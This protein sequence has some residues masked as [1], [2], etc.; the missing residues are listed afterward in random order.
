MP[1]ILKHV[2]SLLLF[3]LTV[4]LVVA[5]SACA[6]GQVVQPLVSTT[7]ITSETGQVVNT[8][9]PPLVVSPLPEP[10]Q[11]ELETTV[12][13]SDLLVDGMVL[14]P[15]DLSYEAISR[16]PTVTEVAIL[17]CPGVYENQ[18]SRDWFGVPLGFILKDADV[19]PGAT[20]LVFYATDGYKMVLSIDM[21]I[22]SAAILAYK[23]DGSALSPGDGY[24]YR[25]ISKQLEGPVW[26]KGID[27]IMVE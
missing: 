16:Y 17:Y 12:T 19:K 11:T 23:V 9:S 1:R 6:Q 15:L 8:S 21:V 13:S 14:T 3:G 22:S 10:N 20:R 25:L 18:P 2:K 5:G 7:F 4:N 27:H 26:V 24:P